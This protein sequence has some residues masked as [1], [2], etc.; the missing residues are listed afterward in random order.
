LRVGTEH[1]EHVV[2]HELVAQVLDEDVL[3]L[4]AQKLGLLARRL[5]LLALAEIGGKRHHLAA[6]GG[7]QPL[8]DDGGVEAAGIGE[9][10]LVHALLSHSKGFQSARVQ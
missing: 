7:L 4:D 2:A 5:Q 6:I 9:H 1:R 3:R 10:D 8:E